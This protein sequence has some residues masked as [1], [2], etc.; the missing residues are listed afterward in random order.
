MGKQT[1]FDSYLKQLRDIVNR[2][3][4][5][6]QGVFPVKQDDVWFAYTIGMTAHGLPELLI[7][8]L[9]GNQAQAVLNTAA[10]LHLTAEMQ[11]GTSNTDIAADDLELRIIAAPR[12]EIG[13]AQRFYGPRVHVHA[14]QLVWP[15]DAGNY[16]GP[17]WSPKF[18]QELF[19]PIWW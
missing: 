17:F 3:G 8:G 7:S 2:A 9:E 13:M 1:R 15:D 4:W 18:K 16:P 6:V 14:V 5:T 10:G 12:A 11:P 19:G